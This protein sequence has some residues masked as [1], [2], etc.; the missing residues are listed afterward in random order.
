MLWA[1][2]PGIAWLAMGDPTPLLTA[3]GTSA[4][5][6]ML[7]SSIRLDWT[8]MASTVLGIVV[9]FLLPSML[10]DVLPQVASNSEAAIA[11]ALKN[12]P[13]L[14][15]QLQP[16]I[17]PMISGVLAALH[18][19]VFMLCLLL[20]RY[21][22]STFY[23][24]GGFGAEFKQLRLPL[25]FTLPAMLAVFGANQLDPE[26]A[27]VMPVF[28]VPLMLAGLALFHGLVTQTKASPTWMTAVYI[29]LFVLGPY[30]YTLLI[31]VA[32]LDSA[33]NFR[34]RLPKDTAD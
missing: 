10:P 30:M 28:T 9:Y 18:S 23:N 14:L 29:G 27:G 19:L 8:V 16:L 15:A 12:E 4:L 7:R 25:A 22:Q 20:G 33:W 17:G 26:L 34:A 24:P 21:W 11:E 2:L 32:C 3:L 6:V 1:L 5:A 31:F 13:Q